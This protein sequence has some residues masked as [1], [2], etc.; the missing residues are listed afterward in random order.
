MLLLNV[1][2]LPDASY[3]RF[4]ETL[5]PRLHAVHYPLYDPGLCDARV[6]LRNHA[7]QDLVE[8][9]QRLRGPRKYLLANGRF[10]TMDTYF[11]GRS[12]GRLIEELDMLLG[13]GVLDGLIFADSY[14]LTALADA[15]PGVAAR[16]EAV[17]SINFGIDAPDQL[18]ALME[19]ILE[20]G[21]QPPGKITL[22][23]SLNRRPGALA[24]LSREIRQRWPGIRIELLANEGCLPHCPFRATHEALIAA[25]NAGLQVDTRRL[26]RDLACIR[27]LSR[28]PHRIFGSPFIRPEDLDRYAAPADLI[29]ICGRTLGAGFL[30]RA[31]KAY[32]EGCYR[33]NLLDLLDAAH[34]MAE[35]WEIPNHD[36]PGDFL[37]R[38]NTGPWETLFC[39]HA[40]PRPLRIAGMNEIGQR[41]PVP[42]V[43][44]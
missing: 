42:P 23:R 32:A 5:G 25:A 40:R 20:N 16:L 17:P 31:V 33:D 26:N 13:A 18:A 44:P 8:P 15:A 19:L 9:L 11:N 4:L 34:W 37:D 43:E 24:A 14:L 6:R 10:Q 2:F 35:R 3:A 28:S 27:V 7:P 36:L 21:F 39:R 30:E 1:P 41:S 22:D 29:K 12:L 38:L